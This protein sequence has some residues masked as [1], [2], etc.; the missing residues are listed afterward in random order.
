MCI[1]SAEITWI[2][3][4]VFNICIR[5][6]SSR[7]FD[8]RNIRFR[9]CPGFGN[10]FDERR[11]FDY[12]IFFL[13]VCSVGPKKRLLTGIVIEYFFAFGQMILLVF[14]YFI[15]YWRSLTWSISLFTIPYLA[16]YL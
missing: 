14:A 8:E 11:F 9:I 16:F 1:W 7:M 5:E 6:I 4:I 12:E 15:R 10:R 13:V 2:L 3:E